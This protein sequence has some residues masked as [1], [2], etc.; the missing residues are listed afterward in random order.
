MSEVCAA[1][2]EVVDLWRL[3]LSYKSHEYGVM[4]SIQLSLYLLDVHVLNG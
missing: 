2:G 3:R 1:M 4:R